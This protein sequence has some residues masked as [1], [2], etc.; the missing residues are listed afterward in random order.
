MKNSDRRSCPNLLIPDTIIYKYRHIAQWFFTGSDGQIKRKRKT[1]L[2]NADIFE[3]LSKRTNPASEILS[4]YLSPKIKPGCEGT[5]GVQ[6]CV[7][8]MDQTSLDS[9]LFQRKK[10]RVWYPAAIRGSQ[11]ASQ[12]CNPSDLV[13][14]YDL[15]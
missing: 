2:K 15:P 10:R 1:H 12:Q 7:E 4:C 11:G 14:Q 3:A 5:A 9:F 6:L 8:Y 13:A